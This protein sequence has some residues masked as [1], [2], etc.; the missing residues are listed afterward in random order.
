MASKQAVFSMASLPEKAKEHLVGFQVFENEAGDDELARCE[1]LM[2]WPTRTK[3]EL[4]EKMDDLRMVQ[5]LSAGVDGLDFACLPKGV[6]VYS[7][8]GAY[9]NSVAEHG[10]GLLLGAAKGLH[11]RKVRLVPRKLGG[12]T[13]LVVGCGSIGS[14]FA[15][16]GRSI[17][18]TTL[19]VS[20]SF[21]IPEAFDEMYAQGDLKGVIGRADAIAIA[22]PL[23]NNTPKLFDYETLMLTN[24]NVTIVNVGRG[25]TVSERGLIKWLRKRPGSRYTTDVFWKKD[26]KETFETDAW[27]LQNFSGTLHIAGTPMG[28]TLEFPLVEAAKNVRRFLATGEAQNLVDNNEYLAALAKN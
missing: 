10:W 13:L 17:G 18:M 1:V 26:G 19:G 25:D 9:T 21:K 14:E 2:A 27:V 11:A 5:A 7:N 16:F 12:K 20:R 8:A 22:L 28:E 24:E 15:R 23:T 6:K 3:K 4:L